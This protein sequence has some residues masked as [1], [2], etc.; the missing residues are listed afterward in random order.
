MRRELVSEA[1]VRSAVADKAEGR[2][3]LAPGVLAAAVLDV[4]HEGA[5]VRE[6]EG[7]ARVSGVAVDGVAGAAGLPGIDRAQEEQC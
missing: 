1:E 5:L 2:L 7:R 3:V 4:H 6:A